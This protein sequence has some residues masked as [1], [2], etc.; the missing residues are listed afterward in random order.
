VC[1]NTLQTDTKYTGLQATTAPTSTGN[2]I[3]RQNSYT[4][5]A[6]LTSADTFTLDLIDKAKEQATTPPLDSNSNE[7]HPRIRPVMI[8]GYA[9]KYVMYLHPIPGHEP[10]HQHG[11][12]SGSTSRRPR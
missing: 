3:I 12:A 10:S 1:G 9:E 8:D 2:R 6:S 5:D 7:D 4:D 11:R